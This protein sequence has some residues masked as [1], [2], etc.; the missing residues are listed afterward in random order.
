MNVLLIDADT[1]LTGRIRLLLEPAGVRVIVAEDGLAGVEKAHAERPALILVNS[2]LR[3]LT[4]V[5]AVRIIKAVPRLAEIPVIMMT[6]QAD[7]ETI[8]E[9]VEVG[10]VDFILKSALREANAAERI[11]KRLR[12]AKQ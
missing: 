7:P 6:A 3:R 2:E 5:E 8:R 12:P 11:L 10:A 1:D 4:G 9:A